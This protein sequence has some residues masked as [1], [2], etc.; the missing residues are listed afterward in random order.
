MRAEAEYQLLV[1]LVYASVF[2][3]NGFAYESNGPMI[4]NRHCLHR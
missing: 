2:W 1:C 3:Q 4:A